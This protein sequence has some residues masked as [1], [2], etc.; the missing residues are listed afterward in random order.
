MTMAAM[1]MPVAFRPLRLQ[2]TVNAWYISATIQMMQTNV[3]KVSAIIPGVII[4][5]RSFGSM[6]LMPGGTAMPNPII[7]A[8]TIGHLATACVPNTST[9]RMED[10][11]KMRPEKYRRSE[12]QAQSIRPSKK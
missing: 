6:L 2:E 5:T 7:A 4:F 10:R 12:M 9:S 11:E 8:I 3:S 1:K